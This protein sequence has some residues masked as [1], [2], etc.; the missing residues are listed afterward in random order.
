MTPREYRSSKNSN[1][2][3]SAGAA[4]E[5]VQNFVQALAD[6]LQF[7]GGVHG[8]RNGRLSLVGFDFRAQLLTG[9]GDGESFF[10]EQLL[11]VQ[12]ALD[13]ASSI[14]ALAGAAFDWFELGEFG[15]PEAEHVGGQAAEGGDF[16]DAE[17]EFVG[18][19]DFFARRR[20]RL[21]VA[22]NGFFHAHF[23][24]PQFL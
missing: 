24:A 11:D 3:N 17:I 2:E 16:A 13:V 1:E 14:H 8:K 18:D 20:G 9:A 6:V 12:D 23:F 21:A 19:Q 15:F 5:D 4:V 10:V 7:G 22:R